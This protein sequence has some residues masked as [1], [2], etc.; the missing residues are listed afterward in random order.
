MIFLSLILF[1]VILL[2]HSQ[3]DMAD[4]ILDSPE[5]VLRAAVESVYTCEKETQL[6]RAFAILE[7][8]PVRN[9]K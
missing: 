3:Q 8:L 6:P 5:E 7:C 2:K 4:P 9:P 1:T